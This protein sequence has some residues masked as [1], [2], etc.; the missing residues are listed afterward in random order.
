MQVLDKR[1]V[2]LTSDK[3]KTTRLDNIY[4]KDPS[5]GGYRS[6]SSLYV[7][8]SDDVPVNQTR[9]L[10]SLADFR[11]EMKNNNVF[12]N[13]YATNNQRVIGDEAMHE[14]EL[15][16]DQIEIPNTYETVQRNQTEIKSAITRKTTKKSGEVTVEDT[17]NSAVQ[18][19]NKIPYGLKRTLEVRSLPMFQ[20][21]NATAENSKNKISRN[22]KYLYAKSENGGWDFHEL[23]DLKYYDGKEEKSVRQALIDN[24]DLKNVLIYAA[25]G[26]P[27]SDIYLEQGFYFNRTIAQESLNVEELTKTTYSIEHDGSVKY[28]TEDLPKKFSMQRY[29]TRNEPVG[30][31]GKIETV[32]Y[33]RTKNYHYNE[34]GEYLAVRVNGQLMMLHKD[35]ILDKNGNPIRLTDEDGNPIA[36]A[37]ALGEPIYF[38]DGDQLRASD[39]VTYEQMVLRY[40]TYKTYQETSE[41]IATDETYLRIEGSA[42]DPD[43]DLKGRYVKELE[44]VQPIC[45]TVVDE[46]A[47]NKDFDKYLV[48]TADGSKWVS[49]DKEYFEKNKAKNIF[50]VQSYQK[51]QRCDYNSSKCHVM[52]TSSKEAKV[53]D[54]AIISQ[55]LAEKVGAEAADKSIQFNKF[56]EDYK[57]GQYQVNDLYLNGEL[58]NLAPDKTRYLYTDEAE[59][60]DYANETARFR[61]YNTTDLTSKNGKLVGGSKYKTRDKWWTR[62]KKLASFTF[63]SSVYFTFLGFFAPPL[64]PVFTAFLTIMGA[65]AV[66]VTAY[67]VLRGVFTNVVNPVRLAKR[68]KNAKLIEKSLAKSAAKMDKTKYNRKQ[69]TKAIKRELNKLY[70]NRSKLTELQ[71]NDAMARIKHRIDNFAATGS[72]SVLRVVDGKIK[73]DA[74]NAGLAEIYKKNMNSINKDM[75]KV[76]KKLNKCLKKDG[77]TVKLLSKKKY[78]KLSKELEE[79]KATQKIV[80]NQTMARGNKADKRGEKLQTLADDL[81]LHRIVENN[82]DYISTKNVLDSKTIEVLQNCKWTQEHGLTPSLRDRLFHRKEV[83]A[84]QAMLPAIKA[85][86]PNKFEV[87]K[88]LSEHVE[89]KQEKLDAGRE[90][91]RQRQQ[92]LGALVEAL[93]EQAPEYKSTGEVESSIDAAAQEIADDHKLLGGEFTLNQIGENIKEVEQHKKHEDAQSETNAYLDTIEQIRQ[94]HAKLRENLERMRENGQNI[95]D[96]DIAAIDEYIERTLNADVPDMEKVEELKE[97]LVGVQAM[98]KEV[99][100]DLPEVELENSQQQ[101]DEEVVAEQPA[102]TQTSIEPVIA[103]EKEEIETTVEPESAEPKD[104][105]TEEQPSTGEDEAEVTPIKPEVVEETDKTSVP[106]EANGAELA[107]DEAIKQKNHKVTVKHK[108]KSSKQASNEQVKADEEEITL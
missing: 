1:F 9:K 50:D 39:P 2:E 28:T 58:V 24:V 54:C 59:Y 33:V 83:K 86:N 47:E 96:E 26:E 5:N 41:K 66:G 22:A 95:S 89:V 85:E 17:G 11:S 104:V 77:K 87:P 52:Q 14:P 10:T 75:K 94:E 67:T 49:V 30:A 62:I 81:R 92:E 70:K 90:T 44:S 8:V 43:S 12:F 3:E 61:A 78:E 29:V 55:N 27:L 37:I 34:N 73:V 79:L 72:T 82:L 99:E 68:L 25:N 31:T 46:N 4:I 56:I 103:N 97:S 102:E 18:E 15:F 57:E 65:V 38:K 74:S 91:L 63:Y 98:N 88:P 64:V 48:R 53:E 93:H 35:D 51:I 76:E 7:K 23:D 42:T 6:L 21:Q 80:A 19:E 84:V 69:E 45:Y 60:P 101:K 108:K 16:V 20:E 36:G 105:E 107:S 13:Q 71:F 100:G 40:E 32:S 106:V